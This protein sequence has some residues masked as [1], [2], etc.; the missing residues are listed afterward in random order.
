MVGNLIRRMTDGCLLVVCVTIVS[1]SGAHNGQTMLHDVDDPM[2]KQRP[3]MH[4]TAEQVELQNSTPKRQPTDPIYVSLIPP[5]LD[6]KMQQAEKAKGVM[7]ER[8]RNEFAA[9]PVIK[10]VEADLTRSG[11]MKPHI[12]TPPDVE[13]SPSVSL[14]EAYGIDQ[15]TGKPNR[16]LAVVFEATI[17]SQMPPAT[18]KVS[19]L[20]HAIRNQEVSKR[21]AKQIK[22]VILEKIAP[23]IPAR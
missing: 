14:K 11:L 8:I 2:A 6:E 13:V 10:L 23:N 12:A 9:D 7:A 18:Y 19:E 17:T 22:Q 16:V 21:F 4:E 20:G 3:V 5:V 15:K 1:C